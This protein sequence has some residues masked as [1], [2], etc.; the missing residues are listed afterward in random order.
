VRA[1][2]KK[3]AN[4]A[5]RV[6]IWVATP[7]LLHQ[8]WARHQARRSEAAEERRLRRL[9]GLNDHGAR[10]LDLP[11]A[12]AFV[13]RTDRAKEILPAARNGTYQFTR[14]RKAYSYLPPQISRDFDQQIAAMVPRPRFSI[15][16]P[17]YNT[18]TDLLARLLASVVSGLGADLYR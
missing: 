18:P 5:V 12:I 8:R 14:E 13:P 2:V 9:S 10:Y 1:R 4:R 11:Q 3:L 7:H 6:A 16:V 15:V 17:T